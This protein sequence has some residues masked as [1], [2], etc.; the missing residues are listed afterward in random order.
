MYTKTLLAVSITLFFTS[1][2]QA[3]QIEEIKVVGQSSSTNYVDVIDH[4]TI[5]EAL[6]PTVIYTPGGIG[7]FASYNERGAQTVHTA[8]YKNGVPANDP[9]NGWYDFAHDTATGNETVTVM[10]GPNGVLYGSGSLGGTVFVNDDIHEQTAV[11]AGSNDHYMISSSLGSVINFSGISTSNGSV[12]SDNTEEDSYKNLGVKTA[13]EVGDFLVSGSLNDYSYDY[14]QCWNNWGIFT[15]DCVQKGQRLNLSAR[16]DNVTVGYNKTDTEY[17]AGTDKTWSSTGERYF[18]DLR[19]TTKF[20][21]GSDV[22]TYGVQYENEKYAGKSRDIASAYLLA[23][24]DNIFSI[25]FRYNEYASTARVGLDFKGFR[26]S[27]GT[28]YRLPTLYELNGDGWVAPN[29]NL[30]SEKAAGIEVG[31]GFI[32]LYRYEFTQGIDYDFNTSQYINTGEYVTQGVRINKKFDVG[33]GRLGVFA[34]YTDSDV[35]N[36]P[37]YKTS[38]SYSL[39]AI[40]H[41]HATAR[42]VTEFDKGADYLG[43]DISDVNTVEF[44][45]SRSLSKHFKMGI[46]VQD[47]FNNKFEIVPD[48]NAGGRRVYLTITYK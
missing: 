42:W 32:D 6:L 39:L 37:K 20:N 3:Q 11:R 17:F 43:R 47:V 5:N 28:S 10:N 1:F 19:D 25:G 7:G 40:K 14:D 18:A 15:N 48:Y 29:H 8:V 45:A 38:I 4:F 23:D 16:N 46:L 36:V 41:W 2:S 30:E 9:S 44:V 21:F 27:V 24:Y 26:A 33:M 31:Y 35:P 22:Y 34:G 13:V 12:R